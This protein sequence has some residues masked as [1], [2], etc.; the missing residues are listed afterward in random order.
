[1]KIL[2]FFGKHDYKWVDGSLTRTG[3]LTIDW[4]GHLVPEYVGLNKCSR[5]GKEKTEEFIVY[6]DNR[7]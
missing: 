1:M 3:K 6:G 4:A 5:C 2:C 7:K